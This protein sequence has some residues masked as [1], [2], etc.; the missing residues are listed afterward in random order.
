M[1]RSYKEL[2]LLLLFVGMGSCS[3]CYFTPLAIAHT[4]KSCYKEPPA[5]V[6]RDG[7]CS[8]CE[9]TVGYCSHNAEQLQGACPLLVI[10][11]M[12]AA[13]HITVD[14][15]SHNEEQ[16]QGALPPAPLCG[17]GYAHFVIV[18]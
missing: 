10:V 5:T 1:K 4:I 9:C 2:L 6:C 13:H 14:Y 18:L 16:L 8:F 7:S 11:D 15:C 17:N 12:G 3:F